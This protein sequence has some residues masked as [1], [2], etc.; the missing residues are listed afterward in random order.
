M[1]IGRPLRTWRLFRTYPARSLLAFEGGASRSV[2]FR[3]AERASLMLND[4]DRE[5]DVDA[6]ALVTSHGE[7]EA[8]RA[9]IR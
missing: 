6:W 9:A 2:V 1:T 3:L 5:P 8:A 7:L 4:F